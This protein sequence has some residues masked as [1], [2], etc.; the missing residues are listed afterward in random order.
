VKREAEAEAWVRRK[1]RAIH[2]HF[3]IQA[4]AVLALVVPFP[5][6]G[7]IFWAL[8]D[9]A[10]PVIIQGIFFL[11]AIAAVTYTAM[12]AYT[13]VKQRKLAPSS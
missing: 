9:V 10:H 3:L 7:V 6:V 2:N 8:F 13:K 5:L 1:R 12:L 11:W 4:I